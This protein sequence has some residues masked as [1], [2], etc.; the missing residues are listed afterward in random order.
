MLPLPV[1]T[2]VIVE[3]V[4]AFVTPVPAIVIPPPAFASVITPQPLSASVP[5]AETLLNVTVPPPDWLNVIRAPPGSTAVWVVSDVTV[6]AVPS[7]LATFIL[8]AVEVA[9]IVGAARLSAVVL[10]MPVAAARASESA[11]SVPAPLIALAA[12]SVTEPVPIVSAAVRITLLASAESV[13]L[14]ANVVDCATV[15]FPGVVLRAMPRLST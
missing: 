11:V 1:V 12:V 9:E 4:P 8:P 7:T 5:A 13:E 6:T 14:P 2:S 3:V 15:T 10:P